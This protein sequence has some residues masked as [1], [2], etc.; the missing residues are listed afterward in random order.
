M[1]EA[2]IEPEGRP[3]SRRRLLLIL[4]GVLLLAVLGGGWWAFGMAN[5]AEKIP[6]VDGP[7]VPLE[8]LTTTVGEDGIHHARVSVAVVLTVRADPEEIEPRVPLLKDALLK[9]VSA[10]DA[11]TIRSAEGSDRLRARLSEQARDIWGEEVVRR[12]VL[13]E[14]LVQ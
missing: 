11:D 1:S 4:A 9:E 6:D 5:A 13:T 2:V 14:L 7:I 10:T 8:P 12:V 3:S